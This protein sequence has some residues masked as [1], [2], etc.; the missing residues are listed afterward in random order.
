MAVTTAAAKTESAWGEYDELHAEATVLKNTTRRHGGP[1]LA[2]E[3]K[4]RYKALKKRLKQ[5]K[6]R[7]RSACGLQSPG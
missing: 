7:G 1:G 4:K 3:E 2:A 6:Q 5:M